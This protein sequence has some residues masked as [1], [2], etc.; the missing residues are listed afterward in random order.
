MQTS[1]VSAARSRNRITVIASAAKQSMSRYKERMDCFAALAMTLRGRNVP[2]R[3]SCW[4]R[5][6]K[7][8][9]CSAARLREGPF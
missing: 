3:P 2:D 1:G 4:L 5:D 9:F 6:P 8:A 7:A